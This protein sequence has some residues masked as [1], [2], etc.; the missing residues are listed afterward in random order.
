MDFNNSGHLAV[1]YA[2]SVIEFPDILLSVPPESLSKF[3]C[4]A[5]IGKLTT[6]AKRLKQTMDVEQGNL[7]LQQHIIL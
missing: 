5:V 7:Y 1:C 4:S 3:P 2:D 6:T